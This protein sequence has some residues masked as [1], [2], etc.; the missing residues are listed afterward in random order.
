MC[1][2]ENPAREPLSAMPN[3]ELPEDVNWKLSKRA[4]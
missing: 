3:I 2:I 1:G 4:N